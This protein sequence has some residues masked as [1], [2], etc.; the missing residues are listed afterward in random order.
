MLG[1]RL[2]FSPIGSATGGIDNAMHGF[3]RRPTPGRIFLLGSPCV[4]V[5][6]ALGHMDVIVALG[7]PFEDFGVFIASVETPMVQPIDDFLGSFHRETIQRRQ[8]DGFVGRISPRY[9]HGQR[10]AALVGQHRPFGALFPSV[11]GRRSRRFAAQG[12]LGN[13]PIEGLPF[14]RNAHFPIL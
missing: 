4:R 1:N 3:V 12:S 6:F 8:G 13:H 7:D 9:L 10:Y 5:G 2:S 11:H 14:P